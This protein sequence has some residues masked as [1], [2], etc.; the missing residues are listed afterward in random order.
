MRHK[1]FSSVLLAS[2]AIWSVNAELV[3]IANMPY[4]DGLGDASSGVYRIPAM[5]KSTNGVIVAVYDCRYNSSGDL[6]NVIDLGRVRVSPSMF[7]I[8][9]ILRKRATSATRALCTIPPA[10]NSG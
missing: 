6:P 5:A 4:D 3:Q 9:T 10:T 7:Q 8:R 1:V 2:M